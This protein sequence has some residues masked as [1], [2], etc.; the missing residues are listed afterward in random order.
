MVMDMNLD[1]NGCVKQHV[2]DG[3]GRRKMKG[4]EFVKNQKILIIDP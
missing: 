4:S 1:E 3:G 2:N